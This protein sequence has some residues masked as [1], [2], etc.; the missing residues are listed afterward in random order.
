MLRRACRR[1]PAPEP[2]SA[3]HRATQAVVNWSS[4]NLGLGCRLAGERCSVQQQLVL[5]PPHRF[6]AARCLTRGKRDVV[7]AAQQ[8][9]EPVAFGFTGAF[10]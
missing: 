10:R 7:P 9:V 3:R 4:W 8:P 1:M 2:S 6:T 5:L